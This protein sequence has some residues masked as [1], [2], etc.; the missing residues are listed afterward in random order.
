MPDERA[1]APIRLGTITQGALAVAMVLV[2]FSLFKGVTNILNAFAVPLIL[3]AVSVGKK[4]RE[5]FWVYLVALIFCAVFFNLQIIFICVY[6]GIAFLLDRLTRRGGHVLLSGFILSVAVTL[7]FWLAILCTDYLFATQMNAI[8]MKVYQGKIVVYIAV[9]YIEGAL[10]G[11]GQLLLSR[12]I[13]KRI[14]RS[15]G[16][17]GVSKENKPER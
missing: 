2:F 15:A 7:G 4:F 12:K 3:Y 13:R 11:S 1:S 16:G 8:M 6:C 17:S 14:F 9:L 5:I 10:V